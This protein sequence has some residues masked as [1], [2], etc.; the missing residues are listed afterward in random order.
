MEID[1]D[2][3]FEKKKLK[4][5]V[6]KLLLDGENGLSQAQFHH[7]VKWANARAIKKFEEGGI[8]EVHARISNLEL[9]LK[10]LKQILDAV[11]AGQHIDQFHFSISHGGPPPNHI[12]TTSFGFHFPIP[13]PEDQ[14]GQIQYI[15]GIINLLNLKWAQLR[16]IAFSNGLELPGWEDLSTTNKHESNINLIVP[17][18]PNSEILQALSRLIQQNYRFHTHL[19]KAI[20]DLRGKRGRTTEMHLRTLSKKHQQEIPKTVETIRELIE[21]DSDFM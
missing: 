11:K 18:D 13:L 7:L 14:A 17:G 10:G 20:D 2:S 19:W 9:V 1:F 15:A 8:S 3:E 16:M 4:D 5:L 21:L 12:G 6:K